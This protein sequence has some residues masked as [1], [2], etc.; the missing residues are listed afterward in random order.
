MAI[1][2][3]QSIFQLARVAHH[4]VVA[5]YDL[6]ADV[7]IVA[8]LTIAPNDRRPFNARA[9]GHDCAFA[10]RNIFANDRLRGYRG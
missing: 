8:N 10:D 9:R 5:D 7:G 1:V 3:E 6:G 4:A 2:E